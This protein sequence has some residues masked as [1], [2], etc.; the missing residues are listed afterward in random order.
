MKH[1]EETKQKMRK[2][3]KKTMPQRLLN[4]SK[5]W[6]WNKGL[7][8][9]TSEGVRG[10]S[11]AKKGIK[12]TDEHRKKNSIGAHSNLAG[13]FKGKIKELEADI[14][15]KNKLLKDALVWLTSCEWEIPL[16]VMIRIEKE[17]GLSEDLDKN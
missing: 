12:H 13:P 14:D 15:R 2:A 6:G 4:L 8:K 17:L 10:I 5:G 16:D 7:T 9:E 11:M 3:A 1:S